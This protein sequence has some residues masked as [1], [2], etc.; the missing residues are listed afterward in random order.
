MDTF[1]TKLV[2]AFSRKRERLGLSLRAVSGQTGIS[3]S[4]LARIERGA[5]LPDNNSK[6]RLL[7]WLGPDADDAGLTFE[8]VAFVHFRAMKNVQSGTVNSLLRAAA[9]LKEHYGEVTDP[10]VEIS[11]PIVETEPYPELSKDQLEAIVVKFRADLKLG[12]MDSIDS[13]QIDVEGVRVVKLTES[14]CFD[15]R[16]LRKLR[17]DA[18]SEWSAMSVPLDQNMEKWAVLLN[19]CHT[20]ERQR[21]TLLEEYWHILMGHKLTKVA[22]VAE[23][24]GRTYDKA[25][26]HDAY[27]LA[28]AT[29]LP[30]K[31]VQT[32]VGKGQTSV[33]IARRFGTSAELVEYRIKRLG[34]WREHVGKKVAL[35]D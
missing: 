7:E 9:C 14:D 29:L 31:A 33:E 13:L 26:E 32:A 22:R 17:E 5:G 6:I 2:R 20:P 21:V 3:F 8:S 12:T 34:L 25:E 4:T 28:S 10:G 1:E 15:G 30:K 35:K 24:Y 19:D 27:Y 16:T 18:C 23:V 11:G